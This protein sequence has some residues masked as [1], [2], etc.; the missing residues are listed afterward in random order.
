MNN[1]KSII[2]I[3]QSS[4]YLMIDIINAYKAE[5]NDIS[6]I[7]GV[8]NERNNRLTQDINVSRIISPKRSNSLVRISTWLIGFS[9]IWW[10]VLWRSSDTH[11]FIVS[12]PPLITFLPLFFRNRCTLLLF[13]IYPD[14][15]VDHKI[16][17]KG[18]ILDMIWSNLNRICFTKAETVFT[19]TSSMKMRV[20][21][22]VDAKKI[23]VV[24]IW[25]ANNFFVPVNSEDNIF[26]KKYNLK[27][28]FTVLY[29]GNLG[30]THNVEALVYVAEALKD[31]SIQVIIIG[32]GSKLKTIKNLVSELELTNCRLLPLQPMAV[33]PHSLQSADVGVVT[34]DSEA[35]SL[36]LPSKTFDLIS[37]GLPLLCICNK[38]SELAQI[39]KKYVIGESYNPDDVKEMAQYIESLSLDRKLYQ[40]LSTNARNAAAQFTA[41]NAQLFLKG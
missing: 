33:L 28:E 22:Y 13:D 21:S 39:V 16:I 8:L 2:F 35:S 18:S 36:S 37:V 34:L 20:E 27:P 24:P 12:N 19:I 25:A 41:K 3:N 5:Y 40:E 10:R 30:T 7:T 38:K 29:S 15:L 31:T 14:T 17:R 26:I 4:G 11:L 1:K 6:L 23:K 32:E 9:Q